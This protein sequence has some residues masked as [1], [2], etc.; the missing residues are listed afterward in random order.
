MAWPTDDIVTTAVDQGTDDPSVARV[1]I[2]TLMSRVKAIIAGRATANGVCE[3]DGGQKIPLSR[4]PIVDVPRGGTGGNSASTARANLGLG[5]A[6]T[7]GWGGPSGCASTDANGECQQI[8]KGAAA[9]GSARFLRS[10]GT[11]QL[12]STTPG[13]GEVSQTMLKTATGIVSTSGNAG[14]SQNLVLPGGTYGFYPQV[15]TGNDNS[16][17]RA[18]VRIAKEFFSDTYVTRIGLTVT[19]AAGTTDIYAQQRYVQASPPYDLGDGEVP[20]FVFMLVSPAGAPVA[21][22]VAPE[23]PWANNGPTDIRPEYFKNGRGYQR[24]RRIPPNLRADLEDDAK[25]EEAL[26]RLREEPPEQEVDQVMKQADM[27]VIPHPFAEVPA[28]HTVALLDP[29][30][31]VTARVAELHEAGENVAELLAMR[32]VEF[33]NQALRRRGPLGVMPVSTRWKR[34]REA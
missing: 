29:V 28:D 23:P 19:L 31:D 12:I 34:T 27:G 30:G 10:D 5:T 11:W 13:I 2:Y 26:R 18:E 24:R 16:G 6:A 17:D 33:G 22:Y 7:R 14:W 32:Y 1:H 21:I 3:L 9:A 15:R 20:I 8:Y 25:R 4:L